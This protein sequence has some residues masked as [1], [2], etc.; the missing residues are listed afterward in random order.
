VSIIAT[1]T[2]KQRIAARLREQHVVAVLALRARGDLQPLPQ[3]VEARGQVLLDC[4]R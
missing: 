4:A 1:S 3:Q 2:P